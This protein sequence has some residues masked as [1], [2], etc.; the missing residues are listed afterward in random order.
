M[1][2][3]CVA[4]LCVLCLPIARLTR[5]FSFTFTRPIITPTSITPTTTSILRLRLIPLVS[6]TTIIPPTIRLI[7]LVSL[8]NH[9]AHHPHPSL[10]Q[11][12]ECVFYWED[13]KKFIKALDKFG[14]DWAKV[15]TYCLVFVSWRIWSAFPLTCLAF[16]YTPPPFAP[17][18]ALIRPTTAPQSHQ[19]TGR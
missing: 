1:A 9:H 16:W 6:L 7:H 3:S 4:C 10:P 19:H 14:Q 8:T 17:T 18:H 11:T 12:A 2:L 15:R 13:H 5:L